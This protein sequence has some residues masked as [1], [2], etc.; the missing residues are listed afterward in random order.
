MRRNGMQNR[1]LHARQ[2]R[3]RVKRFRKT[4]RADGRAV[5]IKGADS[6]PKR[7]AVGKPCPHLVQ[8]QI[9]CVLEDFRGAEN[10]PRVF[11]LR[12]KTGDGGGK[13]FQLVGHGVG[14]FRPCQYR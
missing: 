3:V 8:R 9:H 6:P 5:Q 7:L 11:R 13:E 4:E 12:V 1:R 10:R 2:R 14:L